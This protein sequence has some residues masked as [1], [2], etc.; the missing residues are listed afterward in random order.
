MPVQSCT[1]DGKPGYKYGEGGA[2]YTYTPG[3]KASRDAAYSKA[4]KQ[5]QAIKARQGDES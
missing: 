3:N 2:C 5:G 4:V 1:K